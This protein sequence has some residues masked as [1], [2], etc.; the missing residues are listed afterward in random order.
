M[1]GLSPLGVVHTVFSLVALASGLL[2]LVR[3]HKISPRNLTGKIYVITTIITCLTAF[4]LFKHGFG[5]GHVLAILTL[6]ALGAAALAGKGMFGRV[7]GYVETVCYSATFLFSMIPGITET[8][9]RLPPSAP[10]V[11][12]PDAPALQMANGVLFVLFLI[13]ATLQVIAVRRQNRV[14]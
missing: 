6:I 11:A 2:A 10:L 14:A 8:S 9:T 13:G 3:D 1:F 12:S 7:S 4:G 5:P